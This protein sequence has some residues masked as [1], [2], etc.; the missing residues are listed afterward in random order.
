[1]PTKR[2]PLNRNLH[3]A[4]KEKNDE[5]YTRIEDIQLEMSRY[6]RHFKNKTVL[7]NCD[8]P[9]E[10][11]F[12]KY[13]SLS[14][15]H[16]GLKRLIA[17]CYRNN[18]GE[19]FSALNPSERGKLVI[20]DGDK[21][22]NRMPDR[23]EFEIQDLD[24]D[25]DFRSQECIEYLQQADI[26]VTNPPFSI[27]REYVAQLIEYDKKFL[28]LGS[29]NAITYKEIFPLIK[30]NKLW[31]G[32]YNGMKKFMLPDGSEKSFGNIVWYTNMNHNIRNEGVLLYREY[33][34]E[35]YPKYDNYDA[36]E[37][38]KVSEIPEDYDGVMGVP[39]T[40]LTKYNPKQFEIFGCRKGNDGIDVRVNGVDKYFRVFIRRRTD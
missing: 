32:V 1:M 28:I 7:C 18:G 23:S 16:L 4:K 38:S 15:E 14:F 34:P 37:V 11:W 30:E 27:F 35:K 19:L 8:D 2:K 33:K 20:Y 26:V 17:T 39:I 24:G 13:F 6:K 40:F 29:A 10:S 5:F 21:N 3:K 12:V 36:I 9:L 31:L 22:G 25:G